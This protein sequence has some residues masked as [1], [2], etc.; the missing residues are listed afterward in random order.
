MQTMRLAGCPNATE[1]SANI[2]T[3]VYP[4]L[5]SGEV[6][7][8][9]ISKLAGPL[10][11]VLSSVSCGGDTIA[12]TPLSEAN[13]YV[14]DDELAALRPLIFNARVGT[15][16]WTSAWATADHRYIGTD[17]RVDVYATVSF[18]GTTVATVQDTEN[19][20]IG[21]WDR[22]REALGYCMVLNSTACAHT[23]PTATTPS[24]TVPRNCGHTITGNARHTAEIKLE[25]HRIGTPL[26]VFTGPSRK[27]HAE[28]PCE[29]DD[30]ED[31]ES[32]GSS[33]GANGGHGG[34]GGGSGGAG[35]SCS[36]Y[37]CSTWYWVYTNADDEV[38]AIEIISV[39]CWCSHWQ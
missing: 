14:G 13:Y 37:T 5:S 27:S 12:P 38:V 36:I 1:R 34:S 29:T 23:V 28:Y 3:I 7:T 15:N 24:I 26:T 19:H 10:V 39:D 2:A 30:D 32:G 9:S 18:E 35:P 20:S 33:G 22:A 21:L 8:M 31:G 16:M 11:I 25:G 4:F 6:T 17:G